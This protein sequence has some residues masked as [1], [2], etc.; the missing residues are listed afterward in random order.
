MAK[1][2]K[3]LCGVVCETTGK[4]FKSI[5]AASRYAKA[6][7]WTMSLKM[8]AMGQ[9]TDREGRV[10]KRLQP[11]KSKN[12]YTSSS[13]KVIRGTKKK[14]KM[15]HGLPIVDLE[16]LPNIQRNVDFSGFIKKSQETQKKPEC[17][18][19]LKKILIEHFTQVFKEKGIWQEISDV[20]DYLGLD[21]FRFKRK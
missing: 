9:F 7:D 2:D 16:P 1:K 14:E 12:I 15:S 19:Y 8:T 13:D 5:R 4:V 6:N 11:M 20:M 3:R 21:E 18:E 17:P 10:Y